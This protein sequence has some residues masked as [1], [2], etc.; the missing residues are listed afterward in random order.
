MF[1]P[2]KPLSPLNRPDPPTIVPLRQFIPILRE[3]VNYC[4]LEALQAGTL[5]YDGRTDEVVYH[6]RPDDVALSLFDSLHGIEDIWV[7]QAGVGGE[8]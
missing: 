8:A 2:K 1:D 3:M 6:F 5:G 7:F 4:A